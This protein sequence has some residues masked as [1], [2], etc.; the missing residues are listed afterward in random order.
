[1][2]EKRRFVGPV[3]IVIAVVA[4]MPADHNRGPVADLAAADY[5]QRMMANDPDLRRRS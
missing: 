4:L 2:A 3:E 5:R 1:V